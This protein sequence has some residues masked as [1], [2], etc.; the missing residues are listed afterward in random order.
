MG[1]SGVSEAGR[2]CPKRDPA[3]ETPEREINWL[4]GQA[5]KTSPFHGGNTSSS[6]VGV[7]KLKRV[8]PVSL[9]LYAFFHYFL[10]PLSN[11]FAGERFSYFKGVLPQKSLFILRFSGRDRI[12]RLGD[13]MASPH[14]TFL[15]FQPRKTPLFALRANAGRHQENVKISQTPTFLW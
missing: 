1:S 12:Y 6:L 13:R 2:G 9:G 5:V 4:H 15:G 8:N 3:R 14:K 11:H 10:C 7:T